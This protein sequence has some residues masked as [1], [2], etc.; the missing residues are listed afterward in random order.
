VQ[1]VEVDNALIADN[2][3]TPGGGV[4]TP[5]D[6]YSAGGTLTSNGYNLVE[7][8]HSTCSF[9]AAGDQTGID[10]QLH[11]LG[12][13]GCATLL[14]DGACLPTVALPA[15]SPAVD[16]GS[17]ALSGI[18]ADARGVGR[19][20]DVA[21][22]PDADDGCD[23]GAFELLPGAFHTLTPCR[24]VDTRLPADAPPLTSNVARA[25]TLAGHCGI[26]TSAVAVSLN[27]TL[28]EPTS[29]GFLT[30]YPGG[31]ALPATSTQNFSAGQTRA[32]NL[33]ISLAADG[34]GTLTANAV[35]TGPGTVHLILDVNGYFE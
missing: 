35:V 13:N 7:N 3:V 14:P 21:G 28:T 31:S 12:D 11:P 32:N 23:R 20:V 24:L 30:L 34:S 17:C 9:A 10:P 33:V 27:A 4:A 8:P 15:T 19:P 26:P 6:C 25:F 1:T 16:A 5:G 22:A 2:L 18:T 29:S